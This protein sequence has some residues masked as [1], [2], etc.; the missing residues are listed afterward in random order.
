M[1]SLAIHPNAPAAS[2][3]F[4]E[5]N[6]FVSEPWWSVQNSNPICHRP[7]KN[8]LWSALG[9]GTR[10]SALALVK[11]HFT[12]NALCYLHFSSLF[13]VYLLLLWPQSISFLRFY[14]PFFPPLNYT[15]HTSAVLS[16]IGIIVF[17][18][19]TERIPMEGTRSALAFSL[20][21]FYRGYIRK[22]REKRKRIKSHTLSLWV[23][24]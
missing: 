21:C 13:S 14:F 18:R 2:Q 15:P 23:N 7:T 1:P 8:S 12:S 24:L 20:I 6:N 11:W 16:L 10:K 4:P 17:L 3:S 5:W 9:S 22:A 19:N